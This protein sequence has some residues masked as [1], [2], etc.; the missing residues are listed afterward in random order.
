MEQF[1]RLKQ[2]LSFIGATIKETQRYGK[3]GWRLSIN[4][5]SPLLMWWFQ[6]IVMD[7]KG[8]GW[9]EGTEPPRHIVKHSSI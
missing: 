7:Y 1:D 4:A 5:P 9:I 8:E 3:D 6:H 2:R